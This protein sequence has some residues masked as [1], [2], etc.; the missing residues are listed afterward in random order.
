MPE[1]HVANAFAEKNWR[2]SF[3]WKRIIVI[4]KVCSHARLVTEIG[5]Y[6][7]LRLA[8]VSKPLCL[9]KVISGA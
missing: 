6:S 5:M 8:V 4:W 1:F 7:E 2:G 3:I 9:Y